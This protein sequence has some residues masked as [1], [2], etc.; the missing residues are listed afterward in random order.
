MNKK[1]P[2]P[3]EQLIKDMGNEEVFKIRRP[4]DVNKYSLCDV[5]G[6]ERED[7]LG[8]IKRFFITSGKE[9]TDE[10]RQNAMDTLIETLASPMGTRLMWDCESL[11]PIEDCYLFCGESWF[12][13]ILELYI[14]IAIKREWFRFA[15][16]LTQAKNHFEEYIEQ[17]KNNPNPFI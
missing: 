14:K 5:T 6:K 13:P 17:E 11:D 15:H 16:N 9:I 1:Y 10:E 7:V 3:L 8:F 4:T 12:I 2:I